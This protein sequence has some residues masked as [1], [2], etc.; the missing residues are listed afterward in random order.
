M[1]IPDELLPQWWQLVAEQVPPSGEPM[2]QKLALAHWIARRSH[3][4]DA[5]RAAAEHFTRVVRRQEA[6][7]EIPEFALPDVD[8]VHLP[9][10]MV[11]ALGLGSTSEGRRLIQQGGVK[12]N[13]AAVSGVDVPRADLVG[14]VL[15]AGRRRFVRLTGP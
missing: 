9:A 13:G 14:A 10:L 4:E 5:A 1:S 11:P 15:Q 8:P 2:E 3:G 7:E 6:P 12:L